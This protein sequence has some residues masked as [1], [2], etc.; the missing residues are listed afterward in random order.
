MSKKIYKI[1]SLLLC[2]CLVFEQTG[3]AQGIG[4]LDISGYLASLRNNIAQDK[5]RPP[6]LRYLSYDTLNNNF[7]L[8]IDKGS[9]SVIDKADLEEATKPLMNYFLIGASFFSFHLLLAY[10]V[11][12]ISV[13]V[14]F[15]TASV[16]SVA[17]VVSYMRL[18][19][20]QRFAFLEVGISQLVFLV[21]FSYSFFFKG[22]TGLAIT[23]L[24]IATL[25]VTMQITARVDWDA[26][27][28]VRKDTTHTN[29]INAQGTLG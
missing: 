22:Y 2:F 1:L 17:L 27:F 23:A 6:H 15:I 11:D 3:F 9:N 18:V 5:F 8:L 7:S 14:S 19:V 13:H 10:L 26:V 4:Q 12:H 28:D 24:S 21:L 16:V 25:F 20:E 29:S